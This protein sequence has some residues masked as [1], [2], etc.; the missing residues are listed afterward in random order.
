VNGQR[1]IQR[2]KAVPDFI[3]RDYVEIIVHGV[4]GRL[5]EMRNTP[6]FDGRLSQYH[7]KKF[8]DSLGKPRIDM[9]KGRTNRS[10]RVQPRSFV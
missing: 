6:W 8:R 1:A 3:F 4:L 5:F 2:L 7:L 9:L 10:L